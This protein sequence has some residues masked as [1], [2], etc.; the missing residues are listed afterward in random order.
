M[1]IKVNQE[2]FLVGVG[3]NARYSTPKQKAIVTKIGR[4]WFQIDTGN[5][6]GE[7]EKFSLEDGRCDGKGYSPDW[8]VFE[9]EEDYKES[10]GYHPL[11]LKVEGELRNLTYKELEAVLRFINKQL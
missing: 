7:R 3:N 10:L 6:I 9:T 5:Y 2:V 1:D 8:R 11:L 4:K